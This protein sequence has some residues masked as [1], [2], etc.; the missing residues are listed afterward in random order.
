MAGSKSVK[1][2]GMCVPFRD[3]PSQPK[4]YIIYTII[5]K[6]SKNI[7]YF[8]FCSLLGGYGHIEMLHKSYNVSPFSIEVRHTLSSFYNYWGLKQ[9]KYL[10]SIHLTVQVCLPTRAAPL[11]TYNCIVIYSTE[12][13]IVSAR[14]Y[15]CLPGAVCMKHQ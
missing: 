8:V 1:W 7:V 11:A 5:D 10:F 12:S 9:R 6:L 13:V 14:A 3:A 2:H 4:V 15:A